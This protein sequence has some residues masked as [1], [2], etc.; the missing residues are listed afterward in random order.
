MYLIIGNENFREG[1]NIGYS[2]TLHGAEK[3]LKA[4]GYHK[5]TVPPNKGT[6]INTPAHRDD[7]DWAQIVSIKHISDW[8]KEEGSD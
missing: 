5:C 3:E 1:R 7:G 4:H 8:D 2:F 6:W